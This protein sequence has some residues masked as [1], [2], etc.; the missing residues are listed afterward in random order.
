MNVERL[1]LAGAIKAT[2]AHFIG[3]SRQEPA[4]DQHRIGL[5]RNL[6]LRTKILFQCDE[7]IL[8][9]ELGCDLPVRFNPQLCS[10]N[11]RFTDQ[12]ALR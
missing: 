9:S 5:L 12:R 11:V 4:Q 2:N 6:I 3:I 1:L 10:R 7:L 8:P